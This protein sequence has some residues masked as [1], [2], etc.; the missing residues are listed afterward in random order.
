MWL[1]KSYKIKNGYHCACGNIQY[2]SGWIICTNVAESL[3]RL[4][5]TMRKIIIL[6]ILDSFIQVLGLIY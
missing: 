3:F 1:F 6:N 4:T 2:K 5:M